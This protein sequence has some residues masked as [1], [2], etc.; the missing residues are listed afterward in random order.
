MSRGKS[1]EKKRPGFEPYTPP[2]E[3]SEEIE[4]SRVIDL[5]FFLDSKTI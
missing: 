5:R 2:T 1:A 4:T 3:N